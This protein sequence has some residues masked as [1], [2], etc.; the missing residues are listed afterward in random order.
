MAQAAPFILLAAT[1]V[2]TTLT[3]TQAIEQAQEAEQAAKLEKMA[4]RDR[5]MQRMRE[6]RRLQAEQVAAQA[7]AGL[8][9]QSGSFQAL[10]GDLQRSFQADQAADVLNTNTLVGRLRAR[11]RSAI[12]A[13]AAEAA[14]GIGR[15]SLSLVPRSQPSPGSQTVQQQVGR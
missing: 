10:Q 4:A 2:S 5:A 12:Q 8:S 9:L 11:G 14:A 7:G 1:T 15:S 3:V 6:F 13:G